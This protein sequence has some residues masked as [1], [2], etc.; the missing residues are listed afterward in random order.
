[1]RPPRALWVSRGARRIDHRRAKRVAH[2]R[3]VFRGLRHQFRVA[4]PARGHGV[5]GGNERHVATDTLACLGHESG[6]I[7][8]G[9]RDLRARVVE[10][11][12]DLGAA[13]P[14]VDRD[15]DEAGA[16]QAAGDLCAFQRVERHPRDAIAFAT[17]KTS[18]DVGHAAR[19][20]AEVGEIENAIPVD[21]CGLAGQ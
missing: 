14:V 15:D 19:A 4:K 8:P 12:G 20:P 18:E 10:D 7:G 9:G 5:G 3:E 6:V 11:V 17:A 16:A 21:D 1:M 2:R 13:Q